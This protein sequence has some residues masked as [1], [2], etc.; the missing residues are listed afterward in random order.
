M[1]I[2]SLITLISLIVTIIALLFLCVSLFKK[3]FKRNKILISFII[4]T[5]G[6]LIC[7][8]ISSYLNNWTE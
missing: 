7:T 1:N 3:P 6:L 2:P 8:F 5:I 4:V